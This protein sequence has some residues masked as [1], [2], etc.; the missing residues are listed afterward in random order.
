MSYNPCNFDRNEYLAYSDIFEPLEIIDAAPELS[1]FNNDAE[2]L[3]FELAYTRYRV[4]KLELE[5]EILQEQVPK[6]KPY[7][8]IKNN[9]IKDDST[10][11]YVFGVTLITI[12]IFLN[13]SL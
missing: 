12:I 5:I 6:N 4:A 3:A 10:F 9:I 11:L 8:I 7:Y 1:E 13:L 2:N